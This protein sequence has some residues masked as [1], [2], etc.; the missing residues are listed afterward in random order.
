MKES[1]ENIRQICGKVLVHQ[2]WDVNNQ[3]VLDKYCGYN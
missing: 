3:A 2:G 1:A